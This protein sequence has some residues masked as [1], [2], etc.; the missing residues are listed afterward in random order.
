MNVFEK[1]PEWAEQ[2]L[3]FE[4]GAY[5]QDNEGPASEGARVLFSTA[6]CKA[7]LRNLR[8]RHRQCDVLEAKTFGA[9]KCMGKKIAAI[10]FNG[11]LS[12]WESAL[13]L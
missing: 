2:S 6:R 7:K 8:V 5:V 9:K 11:P 13:Q 4:A 12:Y 1:D 10:F 3:Y